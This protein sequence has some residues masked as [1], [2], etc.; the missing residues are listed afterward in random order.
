VLANDLA[1]VMLMSRSAALVSA[2]SAEADEFLSAMMHK[3]HE[4]ELKGHQDTLAT[5]IWQVSAPATD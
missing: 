5:V 4:E 3:V 1:N 2:A